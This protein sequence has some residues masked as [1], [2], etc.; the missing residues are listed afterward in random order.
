MNDTPLYNS[1]I[2]KSYVEYLNRYF[3]DID[4]APILKYAN[5]EAYQLD[6][7]GH[8]LTQEQGD[9]F[10]AIITKMTQDPDISRKVGRFSATSRASGALG[11]YVIGL[12]NPKMAYAILGNL[13]AR[14]SRG[15]IFTTKVVGPYQVEARAVLQPGVVEKPYQCLNR[16]GTLESMTKPFTDEFAN[17]EHPVC[18]HKGG[19][20][21]LYII[22]WKKTRAFVWKK[23]RSYSLIIGFVISL[24]LFDILKPAHW[25]ALILMY[26][27]MVMGVTL[28]TEHL[29]KKE[30]LANIQNQGDSA[31][32]LLEQINKRYNESLLIQEIGQA[33]SMIME[34]D[35]LLNFIMESLGKRLDFDR[36]M[37]MLANKQKDSLVY[38]VSYG[39]NPRDENFVKNIKFHL[40]N[41]LSKGVAV[42]AFKNQ[43]PILV[44]DISEIAN[45]LSAK[46]I[47]F[48]RA[49]G[50]QSFIVV[51]I[52]YKG[53]SI[54][55]MM[56]DNVQSK[57]QLGQTEMSLLMGI[58]PQI[59]ISINNAISYQKIKESE[60]RFR[61]LS[62]N[63]PDIIYTLGINGEFTYV[64]PAIETILGYRPEEIIGKHFINIARKEEIATYIK[65]FKQVRDRKQTIKEEIG[66]L[67]HKDGTERY[68]SLSGAPN[69]DSE[70][71]F[72]GLVGTFKNLTDIR[73]SEAELKKSLEK[74]QSAMSS[75]IDAISLIVESRDP[76]T[77]GHQRRV[78]KLAVAIAEK[79]GLSEEKIEFIRMGSLIHDIG[80]IYIPASILTKPSRLSDLEFA[81]MKTHP[82]VGYKILNKVDF[83]PV[84]VDIVYQHHERIDGS[85]YPLGISG[86]KIFLES[87]I[88]AVADTVEAIASNRPYR[89]ARG[90]AFALEEIKKQRGLGL[91]AR[92]VD[93]C[94][95]L[96]EKQ[97][98]E[99]K[100]DDAELDIGVQWI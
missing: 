54:G 70:G 77:A 23:I 22:R 20:C 15:T 14:L 69:F 47:D 2:F 5:I 6:D 39:Y 19:D 71:N 81:M 94:L 11:Q 35:Q 96:F 43:K 72:I 4:I 97:G 61:S 1:R 30:L 58:A 62:E 88:V 73:R 80:K 41:P 45:D 48:V 83:I 9:R 78:A 67:L 64:N 59:G 99:F 28:Y 75:T 34:E 29:E 13:N 26:M 42:N 56:V 74:L 84:I 46:S 40:D 93:T 65:A 52:V 55:I 32:R 18:I 95:D 90:I 79:L 60:A 3:P 37:I 76:Y 24:V 68:F 57:K 36:G 92:V 10:N 33:S 51:P 85:G 87:R 91:D 17:I 21:C 49:M 16:L 8:W 7:E 50:A 38:T 27:I 25:D 44:N 86:D 63:A 53:E 89:P 82:T 98:F 100:Q 66:T 31:E 12:I